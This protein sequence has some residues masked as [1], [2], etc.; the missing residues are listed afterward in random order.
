MSSP[1]VDKPC[2]FPYHFPA[3]MQLEIYGIGNRRDAYGSVSLEKALRPVKEQILGM[4][5]M[6][7]QGEGSTKVRHVGHKKE[8]S[9]K[10]V[11]VRGPALRWD[12]LTLWS[13]EA[14]LSLLLSWSY[15][16]AFPK[17]R[18]HSLLHN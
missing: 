11:Q 3:P 16:L 6:S 13:L 17:L 15:G 8:R 18:I 1:N 4:V 12:L 10:L 7:P 14:S 2:L 9:L 5:Q